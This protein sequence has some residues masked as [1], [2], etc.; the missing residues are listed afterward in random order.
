[1]KMKKSEMRKK[2]L[3]S[4]CADMNFREVFLPVSS[5]SIAQVGSNDLVRLCTYCLGGGM[6]KSID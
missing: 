2:G 3:Q 5:I 4:S 1:M 6:N